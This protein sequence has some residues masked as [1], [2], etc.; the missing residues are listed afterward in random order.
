MMCVV[1]RVRLTG[2]LRYNNKLG[3]RMRC[4]YCFDEAPY[5][6]KRYLR[7]PFSR[8]RCTVC[9]R[10]YKLKFSTIKAVGVACFMLVLA[11]TP[12]AFVVTGAPAVLLVPSIIGI[13]IGLSLDKL[14]ET[15]G[16]PTAIKGQDTQQPAVKVQ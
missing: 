13:I 4:P 14:I 11:L 16:V 8:V 2:R 1:F 7:S 10:V 12:V 6:W 3:E 9:N 5:T 15:G